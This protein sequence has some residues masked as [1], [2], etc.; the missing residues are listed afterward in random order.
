MALKKKRFRLIIIILLFIIYFFLAARPVPHEIILA[1]KWI[2]PLT[3]QQAFT[4]SSEDTESPVFSSN[5]RQ[6]LLFPFTLG[7]HFGYVDSAGRFAVNK[8]LNENIY[9]SKNM[10]TEY[11]AEPASI[12]IKNIFDETVTRMENTAGYPI[13]LDDR[14]FILGSDQNSLSEINTDGRLLWTY[15]F[16]APLTCID[17]GA[18]LVLTGS[19]DGIIEVFNSVGKRVFYFEPGGSRYEVILGCAI[20]RDGSRIGIISGVD[21]QRFLLLERFGNTR[22]GSSADARNASGFDASGDY[23]VVYHEFLDTGFRRPVRI[24]FIDEDRRIVFERSGGI[25]CYNIR[26]RRGIF[27]PLDGEIHAVEESGEQGFFFIIT[28]HGFNEKKLVGIRFPQDRWGWFPFSLFSQ[29]GFME[30]DAIFLKAQFKS[31]AVFLDRTGSM[32]VVG[33]GT[34]LISFALEEK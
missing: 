8:T 22:G 7:R 30:T 33:G 12:E 21:Q 31:D 17:A 29:N 14:I 26:T 28:A 6:D 5:Y 24:N 23:K 9:L 11:G 32:L 15:E 16:G 25:G 20:S 2:S 34:T 27:I 13:L 10:W 18:G 3:S 1:N 4:G 19:L